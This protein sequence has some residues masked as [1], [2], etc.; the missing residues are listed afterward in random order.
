MRLCTGVARLRPR[1]SRRSGSQIPSSCRVWFRAR[2]SNTRADPQP[3]EPLNDPLLGGVLGSFRIERVLGRGAMGTVYFG[4]HRVIGSRVAIKVMHEELANNAQHVARF[5]AEARAVN[6]VGH[7]NIVSVYDLDTLP[8]NRPYMVM[9]Y[10]EGR[11]MSAHLGRPMEARMLVPLLVQACSGLHAA[12]LQGVIHRDLKPDNIF[13]VERPG[14]AGLL[15][16]LL[17]FGVAKLFQQEI[18][19]E[20]TAMGM[21]LGTPAY[22]A[23]EQWG[24]TEV[25]PRC[26]V[27]AL[28]VT[29]WRALVGRHP[30]KAKTLIDLLVAH[31]S[32]VA[33][34]PHEVNGAVPELLSQVVMKAMAKTPEDRFGSAEDLRLALEE[35][36]ARLGLHPDGVR[37]AGLARGPQIKLLSDDGVERRRF[38]FA[39]MTRGGAFL[40]CDPPH[41]PLFSD[42]L[43]ELPAP[44]SPLRVQAEVVRQVSVEQAR[45]WKMKPGIG[46]QFVSLD[47]AARQTLKAW[48]GR[49]AGA[50]TVQDDADVGPDAPTDAALAEDAWG[51]R[52]DALLESWV[53]RSYG[54]NHYQV[55]KLRMDASADDVKFAQ[56]QLM[57]QFTD[58]AGGALTQTQSKQVRGAMA[59]IRMAAKTL[60]DPRTRAAYDA[61]LSNVRGIRRCLEEG[62]TRAELD[63]LREQY[64]QCHPMVVHTARSALDAADPLLAAGMPEVARHLYERALQQDPLNGELHERVRRAV[65]AC[66]HASNA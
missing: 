56:F 35:V 65:D 55:L 66:E 14:H 38:D 48:L 8:P 34:A 51:Q 58:S 63:R 62:L 22:M 37:H 53:D 31:R 25:D 9:E 61:E 36:S 4:V 13:L 7:E 15:L 42:L 46:V 24:S 45:T 32:E 20:R 6:L 40:Q 12:H 3:S 23:P 29:A 39:E 50:A 49:E 11:P 5:Q 17:D 28:G 64:L 52:V 44:D 43:L 54:G 2:V 41:P 57:Q 1:P 16:K 33:K 27:Y 30:F 59:Q 19:S 26:D 60:L 21:M 47:D 18:A 10:L